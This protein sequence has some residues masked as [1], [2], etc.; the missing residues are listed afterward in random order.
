MSNEWIYQISNAG[1]QD[2]VANIF[3]GFSVI[4]FGSAT[5]IS[6]PALSPISGLFNVSNTLEQPEQIIPV[7]SSFALP[8]SDRFNYTFPATSVTVISLQTKTALD[9]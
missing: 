4:G 1:T 6:S 9:V 2:L 7:S 5:S 3:L 8:F